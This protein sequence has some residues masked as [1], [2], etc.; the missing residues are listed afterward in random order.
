[1][2]KN[3]KSKSITWEIAA[4]I[5]RKLPGSEEGTSYGMPAFR[6]GKNLFLRFH[7]G[8]E[9]IV[10][11]VEIDQREVLMKMYPDRFYITDHYLRYPYMLVR[12]SAIQVDDLEKIIEESWRRN[13]PRKFTELKQSK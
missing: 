11:N 12:L 2:G 13:A 3:T 8:G 6:V 7:Q 5:A 1:M 4:E 10:V 9:A